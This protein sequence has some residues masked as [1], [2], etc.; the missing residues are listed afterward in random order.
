MLDKLKFELSSYFVQHSL[1]Y[2]RV[3]KDMLLFELPTI[4]ADLI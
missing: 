3:K 1:R 2:S 4:F